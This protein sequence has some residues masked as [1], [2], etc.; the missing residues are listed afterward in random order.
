MSPVQECGPLMIYGPNIVSGNTVTI[1][2]SMNVVL[3]LIP[4]YTVLSS[5]HPGHRNWMEV[6]GVVLV[7][8][9][10]MHVIRSGAYHEQNLT[11]KIVELVSYL[12]CIH[13][14]TKSYIKIKLF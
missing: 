9:G 13:I 14:A 10:F 2:I 6:V 8:L 11:I 12:I 7:L 4:Q 1:I 5:I 3:M